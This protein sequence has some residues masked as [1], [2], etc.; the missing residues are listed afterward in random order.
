M[1][2]RSQDNHDD[3]KTAATGA[4]SPQIVVVSAGGRHTVL[5]MLT[6][7]LAVLATALIL[8]RDEAIWLRSAHAQ[9]VSGVG[10]AGA[11]GIY[12]FTGQLTAKTFGLFMMDVDT[13]TIWCYELQRGQHGEPQM[14]LVAARSWIYDRYLEEFNAAEPVPGKVRAMVEQQRSH[15]SDQKATGSGGASGT[16]GDQNDSK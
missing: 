3:S 5:W 10:Q 13:G 6:V 15:R 7:V 11:R 4:S 2:Q 12:A 9:R 8:E 14:K 16:A 1:T